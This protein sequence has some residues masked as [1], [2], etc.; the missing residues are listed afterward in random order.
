MTSIKAITIVAFGSLIASVATANIATATPEPANQEQIILASNMPGLTT[1]SAWME[2]DF[3]PP[4]F[5]YDLQ[6]HQ[7]SLAL[8]STWQS[9]G[10]NAVV[11]GD[12]DNALAAFDKAID[13]DVDADATLL[14][15]RG[16]LYYRMGHKAQALGD[17][18]QAASFQLN[19]GDFTAYQDSMEMHRFVD[20]QLK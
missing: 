12:Y 3:E 2:V 20:F 13:L 11:E 18:W 7:S 9:I 16:W 1:R 10:T 6:A 17:L 4:S 14:Q 19:Q 8:A 15:Q 5:E